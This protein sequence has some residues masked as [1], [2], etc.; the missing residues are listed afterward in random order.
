MMKAIKYLFLWMKPL[1]NL[2]CISSQYMDQV[3]DTFTGPCTGLKQVKK[4]IYKQVS[5]N[6]EN[7]FWLFYK[8]IAALSISDC[9]PF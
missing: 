3:P 5:L 4:N 8:S 2:H 7:V 6:K 9:M 1:H